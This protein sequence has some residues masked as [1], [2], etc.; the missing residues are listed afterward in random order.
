MKTLA[1]FPGRNVPPLGTKTFK[2]VVIVVRMRKQ[3][4]PR[5]SPEL[6]VNR[7]TPASTHWLSFPGFLLRIT[8]PY[9]GD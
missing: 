8:A 1:V 4:F 5:G 7:D 9:N 6:M 2:P 3:K